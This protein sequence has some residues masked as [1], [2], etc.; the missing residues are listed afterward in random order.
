MLYIINEVQ[1][2]NFK[3]EKILEKITNLYQDAFS[4][5]GSNK[6]VV[7]AFYHDYSGN[8]KDDYT[9]SLA[10]NLKLSNNEMSIPDQKYQIFNVDTNLDNGVLSMWQHIWELE[11]RSE[12]DRTYLVDYEK[13][14]VDGQVEIFIG[15]K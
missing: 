10:T 8:Y 7:Y 13:Y 12:I 11:E 4:K 2:N 3:D 14:S 6:T 5:I 9:L 15:I 1:T